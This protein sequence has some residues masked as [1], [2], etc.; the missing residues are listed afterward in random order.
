VQASVANNRIFFIVISFKSLKRKL[1]NYKVGVFGIYE[2]IN[3]IS[4]QLARRLNFDYNKHFMKFASAACTLK[5]SVSGV[6]N[7]VSLD[8]LTDA[9]DRFPYRN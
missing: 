9:I 8:E 3:K 4:P 2:N 7:M 1:R 6:V 5:H